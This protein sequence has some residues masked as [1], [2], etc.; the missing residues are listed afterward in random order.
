MSSENPYREALALP[1]E[2]ELARAALEGDLD[3]G[4]RILW[5]GRPRQGIYF[6]GADVLL[7]PFSL[8]WAGFAFFWE[9]NVLHGKNF[10]ILFVLF[11][12][13]FCLIGLYLVFGRFIFDAL[14][15]ARTFYA[16]TDRRALIVSR[17]T[18]RDLTSIDL[19][20]VQVT[21]KEGSDGSGTLAFGA[22]KQSFYADSSWPKGAGRR[23]GIVLPMFRCVAN[24]RAVFTQIRDAKET[25]HLPHKTADD[26][27]S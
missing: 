6:A 19:E 9:S 5:A 27:E 18:S 8:V 2:T 10:P 17:V 1:Q 26:A 7:V 23:R 3:P 25:L 4:E 11:G 14:L 16:I 24:A 21:L 20:G 12:G 22:G 13:A 15:R